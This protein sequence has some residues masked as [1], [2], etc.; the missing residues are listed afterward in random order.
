MTPRN[1]LS[2]LSVLA[3]FAVIAGI[4]FTGFGLHRSSPPGTATVGQR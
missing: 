4:T 3:A 2:M 1:M